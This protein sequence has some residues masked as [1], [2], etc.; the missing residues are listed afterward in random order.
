MSVN[1]TKLSA[2]MGAFGFSYAPL[3][4]FAAKDSESSGG[5]PQFDPTWF[6]SQVFWL[7]VM[8]VLLYVFFANKTLPTLSSTIE[9]RRRQIESDMEEAQ[10]LSSEAQLVQTNY[11]LSLAEARENASQKR[12][13][14]DQNIS[15]LS[16]KKEQAF[17]KKAEKKIKSTEEAI[18]K[19]KSEAL[20]DMEQVTLELCSEIAKKISG[21]SVTPAEVKK[22]VGS[23][24]TKIDKSKKAA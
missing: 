17:R 12:L 6:P 8:F 11:E 9:T 4:A 2:F 13:E 19:A 1:I 20:K 21:L 22:T 15:A 18:D 5:L 24:E 23:L 7:A 10:K 16:T 14:V 3:M